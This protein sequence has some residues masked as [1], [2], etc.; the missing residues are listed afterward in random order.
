M[1]IILK[2]EKLRKQ[3]DIFIENER[4]LRKKIDIFIENERILHESIDK[5]EIDNNHRDLKHNRFC[6]K[7]MKHYRGYG[8]PND[9]YKSCLIFNKQFQHLEYIN[10]NDENDLVKF[11]YNI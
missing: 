1:M 3:I 9:E 5:L 4:K 11:L 8:M 6:I 2:K 10:F 7:I